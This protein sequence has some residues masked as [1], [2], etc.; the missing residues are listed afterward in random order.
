M[1]AT[2]VAVLGAVRRRHPRVSIGVWGKAALHLRGNV[3]GFARVSGPK[4]L[5][6]AHPGNF[7]RAQFYFFDEDSHRQ[8]ILPWYD[9]HLEQV[10]NQVM[11][12]SPVRFFVNGEGVYAASTSWP[13]P[14]AQPATFYLSAEPSGAV[15]S[16]NDGS[17]TNT[18]PEAESSTSWSYPDPQCMAGVMTFDKFGSPHHVARVNYCPYSRMFGIQT[19]GGRAQYVCAPATQLVRL[20][21]TVSYEAAAALGV[22]YTTTWHGMFECAEVTAADTL[23]V[24]GAGGTVGVAAVQLAKWAGARVIAVT[25]SPSKQKLVRGLGADEVFSYNDDRWPAQV[26][27]ATGGRGVT[28][29]FENSGSATLPLSISCLGRAGRLFCSGGTTGLD[30]TLNIRRLYRELIS[31]L[32]Y[33]QGARADMVKLVEPVAKGALEPVI[34]SRYRLHDAALADERLDANQ[35]FGRIV[36]LV[37]TTQPPTP[38]SDEPHDH[39][40]RP[41]RRPVV[42]TGRVV[43]TTG[44][45]G[46]V[47]STRPR[48][49]RQRRPGRRPAWCEQ[50]PGAK[51]ATPKDDYSVG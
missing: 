29:A 30:L 44:A 16:L 28:V 43:G 5:F 19:R 49:P 20:P 38:I 46:G 24:M 36:L 41:V 4:Q 40:S 27:A 25:G 1:A 14:D 15:S 47:G 37:D 9:H 45:S 6:I 17:L 32:F 42:N 48:L 7:A 26:R 12:R 50:P 2:P 13:P 51:P 3:E 31:L 33:V 8:E 23:L 21:E 22:A 10:D 11:D 34:D 18:P 39:P 35:Q